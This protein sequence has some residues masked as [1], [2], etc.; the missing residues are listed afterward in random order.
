MPTIPP[1]PPLPISSA[2]SIL[3]HRNSIDKNNNISNSSI[4]QSVVLWAFPD[5][6]VQCSC[7]F[8]RTCVTSSPRECSYLRVEPILQNGMNLKILELEICAKK[9][10][11]KNF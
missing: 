10:C 7:Y 8:A 5:Y 2:I 11:E 4:I 9:K 3:K 6:T 1:P